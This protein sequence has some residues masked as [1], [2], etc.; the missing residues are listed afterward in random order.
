[1][2]VD[3]QARQ[4]QAQH[5]IDHPAVLHSGVITEDYF[6]GSR[7]P[8]PRLANARGHEVCQNEAANPRPCTHDVFEVVKVSKQERPHSLPLRDIGP[9]NLGRCAWCVWPNAIQSGILE[10][11]VSIDR[12]CDACVCCL[13]YVIQV[14]PLRSSD[15]MIAC[16]AI[17]GPKVRH[18]G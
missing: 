3:A 18:R 9:S 15:N 14:G 12:C 5:K 2:G 11:I 16:V 1:M 10:I 4:A 7:N 13:G 8:T 6:T 17:V